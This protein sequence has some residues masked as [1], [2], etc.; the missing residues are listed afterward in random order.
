LAWE[1]LEQCLLIGLVLDGGSKLCT[2]SVEFSEDDLALI[3]WVGCLLEGTDE[4]LPIFANLSEE[5]REKLDGLVL[6]HLLM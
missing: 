6:V 5:P 1:S 2:D 3:L 4:V